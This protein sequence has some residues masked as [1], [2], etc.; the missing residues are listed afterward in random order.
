[1]GCGLTGNTRIESDEVNSAVVLALQ[2]LKR[3]MGKVLAASNIPGLTIRLE[4][5]D[6]ADECYRLYRRGE[7][8]MLAAGS[9]LGFVYGI[10]EISR[11]FLG[12]HDFWFWNDQVF[13]K[14]EIIPVE[15]GYDQISGPF[16]IKL[17]GWFVNDE[18]LIDKWSV[19]RDMEEPWRMVFEALLRCGGN[20]VI[21][22]TDKNSV[23][24]RKMASDMGLFI[25]HH[26]AEPIGAEMFARAYPGLTPSYEEHG[27]L[28]RGL[29]REAILAQR[30][31]QVVWN[32][33]FRGQGDCPFWE[34]DPRYQTDEARGAL[35]TRLITL[36]YDMVKEQVPDALCCTNLYGE[37]MELYQKGFLK[38]PED[39]IHIWADNGFGKMVSRRQGNHNPRV[40]A[41]P[42]RG[43]GG[44]HGI[45]YH[46]SFYDLQAANHITM[47]PNST[48]FVQKELKKVLD[49]GADD[50]WIINCSNVKPHVFYLALMAQIWKNGAAEDGW[51]DQYVKQYYGDE[52][53]AFVKQCFLE[54]SR[55]AIKYGPNEDDHAG[56]QFVN[57]VPRILMTQ[58]MK[59]RSHRAEELLWA[60]SGNSLKEQVSWFESLCKP[61]A[62]SYGSYLNRCEE[63][64]GKLKVGARLL[65][66][67]SLLL[68]VRLLHG[69][70]Q[71]SVRVCESLKYG[72]EEDY[73]RAFYH[74]GLAFE[75]FKKADLFM[76]ERE[77][78]KWHDF[79]SNECLADVKQSAW[80]AETLMG[81]F[82]VLGDG[83]HFYQW[84]REFFNS[85]KDRQVML[86]LN[87]EN[88]LTHKELLAF[89]KEKW[90]I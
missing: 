8:L 7:N 37:T 88:H 63:T 10:Y 79:Y 85:G 76:R 36:Q 61:A 12:V 87:M 75:Q 35:L 59:D 90:E 54:F 25:T 19:N 13:K 56:E 82:R 21:P 71:A 86:V 42:V 11:R 29:W 5:A 31:F 68:Q 84:Q 77:H 69:C 70:C 48:D 18:V 33:G 23:K 64:A 3:D 20:M 72:F 1:M 15:E 34:N 67:D 4:K 83:P 24:H 80:V 73:K 9:L 6:I 60:Y 53:L 44:R 74:A 45:Y 58:F 32:L 81:F 89:M 55:Y 66:E 65:F 39:V 49:H 38:L 41:L 2:N 16:R 27:E 14:R 46:A 51:A 22:G 28:F 43:T 78:G 52:Q 50:Y 17:R 62:V 26:H 40:P 47:L 57:H 30:E